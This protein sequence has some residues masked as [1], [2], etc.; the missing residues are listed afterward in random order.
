MLAFTRENGFAISHST[1]YYVHGNGQAE[2]SKKV[3]IGI[4]TKMID[5]NPRVW[6]D[7]LHEALWAYRTSKQSASGVT[8]FQLTYGHAVVLPMELAVKSARIAMQHQL[9]PTNFS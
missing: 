1:P 3:I 7:R 4:I 2:T 6:H 5:E 9:T 8:P